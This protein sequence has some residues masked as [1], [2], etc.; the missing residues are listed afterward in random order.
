MRQRVDRQHV[1]PDGARE[2][3]RAVQ[4]RRPH[5][6]VGVGGGEHEQPLLREERPRR[7]GQLRA[8][9]AHEP[10]GL[11]GAARAAL[12]G[13]LALVVAHQKNPQVGASPCGAAPCCSAPSPA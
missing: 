8:H 3:R 10:L 12:D 6:A 11:V 2:A 9:A 4:R 7:L 1:R 13:E 5:A